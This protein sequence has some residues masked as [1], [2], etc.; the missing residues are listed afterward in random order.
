MVGGNLE[1]FRS[2]KASAT[3][4]PAK[5]YGRGTANP[6]RAMDQHAATCNTHTQQIIRNYD[7]CAPFLQKSLSCR[8]NACLNAQTDLTV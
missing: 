2:R 6:R 8:A 4:E 1:C 7:L 3:H 5:A